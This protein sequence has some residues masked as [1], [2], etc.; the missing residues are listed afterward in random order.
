MT[1]ETPTEVTILSH[2]TK[3]VMLAMAIVIIC[4]AFIAVV[5]TLNERST[6]INADRAELQNQELQDE[7]RCLRPAALQFDTALAQI[8]VEIAEGL[9]AIASGDGVPADLGANLLRDAENLQSAIEL[10]G[11]SLEECRR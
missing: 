6:Q 11:K 1:E 9:A 5:V 8:Q 7:L 10:R 2:T 3:I 4:V